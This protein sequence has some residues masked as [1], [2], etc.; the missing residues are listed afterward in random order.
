MRLSLL[1]PNE[2]NLLCQVICV[3]H[4]SCKRAKQ[5]SEITLNT[6]GFLTILLINNLNQTFLLLNHS[7]RYS[8]H[9][10][11]VHDVNGAQVK[12]I[13]WKLLRKFS[14]IYF[15]KKI[16]YHGA[17]LCSEI[18]LQ[19][20]FLNNFPPPRAIAWNNHWYEEIYLFLWTLYFFFYFFSFSFF[21]K[22]Q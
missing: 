21:L 20:G 18:I 5:E 11:T 13:F 2:N 9:T 22:I 8:H 17:V 10:I 4:K 15:S 16:L 1:F 7:S 12:L 6:A 3:S 14:E 19:E